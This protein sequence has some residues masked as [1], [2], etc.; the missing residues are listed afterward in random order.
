MVGHIV[1]GSTK[2]IE[3]SFLVARPVV[4]APDDTI[5]ARSGEK[6]SAGVVFTETSFAS[7]PWVAR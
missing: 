2:P 5:V 1:R 6:V 7:T 4:A 3:A